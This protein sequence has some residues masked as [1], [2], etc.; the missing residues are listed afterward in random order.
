MQDF[1][2]KLYEP[3]LYKILNKNDETII[4]MFRRKYRKY[5]VIIRR[6]HFTKSTFYAGL[7]LSIRCIFFMLMAET[8]GGD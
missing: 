3:K 5:D 6:Y 2:V 8:N 1:I 4:F 7:V